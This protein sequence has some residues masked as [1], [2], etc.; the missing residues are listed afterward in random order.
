MDGKN[1]HIAAVD[2]VE[3]FSRLNTVKMGLIKV[4]S[5]E[6]YVIYSGADQVRKVI[7]ESFEDFPIKPTFEIET[8]DQIKE[9][10]VDLEKDLFEKTVC[11]IIDIVKHFKGKN[12]DNIW[13]NFSLGSNLMCAACI[14][15]SRI[16]RSFAYSIVNDEVVLIPPQSYD[17]DLE[18]LDFKIL[19]YLE[20]HSPSNDTDIIDTLL[21]KKNSP[22]MIR[23][24]LIKLRKKRYIVSEKLGRENHNSIVMAGRITIKA[25]GIYYPGG[26]FEMQ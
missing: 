14:L 24:S 18:D 10:K 4:P 17:T 9:L 1:V 19:K 2:I 15:A 6:L 7:E 16:T 25:R 20:Q 3:D 23:Y 13:I 8:Y 21:T 11:L 5:D 12:L 22:R 26:I